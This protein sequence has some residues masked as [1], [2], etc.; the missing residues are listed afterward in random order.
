M[1]KS[2]AQKPHPGFTN[3]RGFVFRSPDA[4]QDAAGR[5]SYRERSAEPGKGLFELVG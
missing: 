5:N 4:P 1:K 3:G 2:A